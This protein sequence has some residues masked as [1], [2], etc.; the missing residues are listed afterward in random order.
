MDKKIGLEHTIRNLLSESIG[1]GITTDKYTKTANSFFKPF[2]VE[3]KKG[4]THPDGAS[5]RAARNVQKERTSET[6]KEEEQLDEAGGVNPKKA[7][8]QKPLTDKEKEALNPYVEF[9]K[10]IT[11]ILGT[12]RQAGRTAEAGKKTYAD[13]QKGNYWDAAKGAAYTAGQAALTGVSGVG[14][15]LTIGTLGAATPVVAAVK[16]APAAVRAAPSLIR[17][18]KNVISGEKAVETTK[19]A[20][21]VPAVVK[22]PAASVTKAPAATT[23]P[24]PIAT[25]TMTGIKSPSTNVTTVKT[26][27]SIP[28]P[29]NVNVAAKPPKIEAPKQVEAPNVTSFSSKGKTEKAANDAKSGEE[30][31]QGATRLKPKPEKADIP[32]NPKQSD[33]LDKIFKK[34]EKKSDN[35]NIP[36]PANLNVPP[37]KK[38][39]SAP[40]AAPVVKAPAPAAAPVVKAPAPAAAPAPAVAKPVPAPAPAPAAKSKQNKQQAKKPAPPARLPNITPG[41]PA[42][43]GGVGAGTFGVSHYRHMADPRRS[44]FDEET[45]QEI[46]IVGRPDGDRKKPTKQAEIIRKIIDEQKAEKKKKSTA[47]VN[48]HPKLKDQEMDQN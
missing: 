7:A 24:A 47:T 44:G 38:A 34:I 8:K 22:A 18:I 13:Y 33:V 30:I 35:Q 40:A 27:P 43:V 42:S 37:A 46:A 31:I 21:N 17:T 2:H 4:D 25:T 29:A 15:V 26:P 23:E 28:A 39:V 36:T 41:Q 5:V 19:A 1:S 9:A 6:M 11:P 16:G 45:R 10:D 20:G 32:P 3:P 12:V 14:D 48:L